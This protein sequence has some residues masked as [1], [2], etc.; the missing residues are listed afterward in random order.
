[1]EYISHQLREM[2]LLVSGVET[3]SRSTGGQKIR[4]IQSTRYRRHLRFSRRHAHELQIDPGMKSFA[5]TNRKFEY[6]IIGSQDDDIA[7]GVQNGGANLAMIQMLLHGISRF[8]RQSSVQI[9]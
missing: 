3:G 1:M 5:E 8:V 7:R 4:M 9:F 2:E 6:P